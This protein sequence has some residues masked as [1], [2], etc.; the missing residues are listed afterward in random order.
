MYGITVIW[1]N[2]NEVFIKSK[3]ALFKFTYKFILFT[4]NRRGGMD[5][6]KVEG[7]HGPL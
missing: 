5:F 6:Q 4:K 3:G 7:G 1:E 2:K